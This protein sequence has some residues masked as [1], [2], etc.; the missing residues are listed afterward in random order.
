[1]AYTVKALT[2]G[3]Q[4]KSFSEIP[5]NKC[6]PHCGLDIPSFEFPSLFHGNRVDGKNEGYSKPNVHCGWVGWISLE[7][8]I[9]KAS[10]QPPAS[11][12]NERDGLHGMRCG[13]GSSRAWEAR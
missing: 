9:I 13:H 7:N 5:P 3:C 10:T 8:K 6:E 11:Q 12:L 4:V 1:V 2:N